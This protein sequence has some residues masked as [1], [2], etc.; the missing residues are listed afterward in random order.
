MKEV[1]DFS[2]QEENQP[3]IE[4]TPNPTTRYVD[5]ISSWLDQDDTYNP[6][7]SFPQELQDLQMLDD[8][9]FQFITSDLDS[10]LFSLQPPRPHTHESLLDFPSFDP[11]RPSTESVQISVDTTLITHNHLEVDVRDAFV[12]DGNYL[13]LLIAPEES[14]DSIDDHV[15]QSIMDSTT[16]TA[17][18]SVEVDTPQPI[19]TN[20]VDHATATEPQRYVEEDDE[21]ATDDDPK[22]SVPSCK[23]L[24]SERNRR[25]RLS[26]QLL[27]LRSLVPNITKMDKRSV[28]VDALSY[29][30]G[31]HEETAQLQKELK[32]QQPPSL[33]NL[34]ETWPDN[35]IPNPRNRRGSASN[36]TSRPK[37][38]IIEMETEKMEDRRYVVKITCKGST[39]VGGEILRVV[40]S[41]GFEITYTALERIKPQLLLTTVFVR[42]SSYPFLLIYSSS[43]IPV[44]V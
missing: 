3:T 21:E 29:L 23:N 15:F 14:Q 9:L 20:A 2:F 12:D 5:I 44:N 6:S 34:P 36:I 26:Q 35:P 25:K 16:P 31:I 32:Q 40:E 4:T 17:L 33:I 27:A 24:V 8:P 41:L 38:K 7:S 28:L 30:K 18:D 39:G 11:G 19:N 22:P 13:S 10:N 37:T 42:V 43:L 1:G